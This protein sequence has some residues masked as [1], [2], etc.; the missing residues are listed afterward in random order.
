MQLCGR[1]G[2]G[3]LCLTSPHPME[4]HNTVLIYS[5]LPR[6][7]KKLVWPH[8]EP[9]LFSLPKLWLGQGAPAANPSI[10]FTPSLLAFPPHFFY[11]LTVS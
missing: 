11:F 3:T 1:E 2:L 7:G 4:A 8:K 6:V 10:H 5:G 9:F